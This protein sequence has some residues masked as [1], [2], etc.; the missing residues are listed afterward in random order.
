MPISATTFI[1]FIFQNH[2]KALWCIALFSAIINLLVLT[3]SV[4]MLQVYD[5]VLPS[6]NE[7]TLV[8]LSIIVIGVF[9][10]IALLEYCRSM[11]AIY[12]SKK[13]DRELS[14]AV[15]Q[16]AFY[17]NLGH[18]KKDAA[19]Y[20][21]DVT[22][23]RQFFTGNAIFAF[24][25]A[26]WFPFFI[27]MIFLFNPWLG[28]F[29][30]F[31]AGLLIILAI[32]NQ[33]ITQKPLAEAGK[34]AHQS[35]NIAG[36]N[37]RYAS[38]I[39]AM[40]ML[41]DFQQRWWK[42]HKK[43]IQ[44]Q[45]QASEYNG[46]VTAV[47]RFVRMSLQSLILGLGGWLAIR[48]QLTPGMMIAGSILLGRALAPIEQLITAWKQWGNTQSALLRLEQLL[49][50][51]PPQPEKMALPAPKGA[52]SVEKASLYA[53]QDEQSAILSQID[54]QLEP[55]DILGVIGSSASGKSTLARL[56]VGIQPASSGII[57]FDGA[58]I[59]YWNRAQLG[60]AIGYLSQEV[61]IF[62]GTIAENIA[63]FAEVDADRVIEAAKNAG[64]HE[65][66]LRLPAGYDTPVGN[67][68]IGLSGGQKQRVALARALYGSPKLLVLDE[69][70]ASL[71]DP[72]LI[73][74]AQA[75]ATMQKKKAT[76]VLITHR[77][78]LL[79]LTSKVLVM[80]AGQVQHF[81]DTRSVLNKLMK[82]P[83]IKRPE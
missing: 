64:V 50:E 40:G 62:A 12:I 17:A 34:T 41:P 60:P 76:I 49:T 67:G 18:Q 38:T 1:K 4:Y 9:G 5:R 22:T 80:H 26:P 28:A 46:S 14:N 15:Y 11:I 48:G 42:L 70:D 78:Q 2:K 36:A 66:I 8:M 72:G 55:G 43:F 19:N 6:R 20:L 65:M 30:L 35:A 16:A 81:G 77:M 32:V 23:V 47:T 25:D 68:G 82:Q 39:E 69:P 56:L 71:D 33:R 58:D 57:R 45:Q 83:E 31:G 27:L 63:R 37:L 29:A 61:E 44:L 10:I 59:N 51:Y 79:A 53:E 75:L 54:F 24:I 13:V 74:L 73:A 21:N 3:P 52:I 7:I